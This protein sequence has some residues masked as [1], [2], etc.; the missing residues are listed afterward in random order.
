MTSGKS[1]LPSN[2]NDDVRMNALFSDFR[3]RSVNPNDWDAK[4]HFWR[5]HICEWCRIKNHLTFSTSELRRSFSR[6]GRVPRGLNTVL[7]E[8]TK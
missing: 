4:L 7:S 5:H 2:W 1:Y 3:N 6:N 8:M